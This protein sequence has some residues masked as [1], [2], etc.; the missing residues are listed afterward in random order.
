VGVI[1]KVV[2]EW[3]GDLGCLDYEGVPVEV[4]NALAPLSSNLDPHNFDSSGLGLGSDVM[5]E[6]RSLMR[7]KVA[8]LSDSVSC[9]DDRT[10][11]MGITNDV[12][13]VRSVR[14]LSLN[15]FRWLLVN[16]FAILFS[17]NKKCSHTAELLNHCQGSSCQLC[18]LFRGVVS[19]GGRRLVQILRR[20][21]SSNLSHSCG[22]NLSSSRYLNCFPPIL[23]K[24]TKHDVAF[25]RSRSFLE[26]KLTLL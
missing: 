7:S 19:T 13:C 11:M 8:K 20:T 2:S 15:V 1:R 22:R 14:Y 16:H 18:F 10:I 25:F 9:I 23:A 24:D 12:D 21:L 5:A 3:E 17:H 6:N 4:P 26:A